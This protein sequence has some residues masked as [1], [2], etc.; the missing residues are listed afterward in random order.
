MD[1]LS[2]LQ[3]SLFS[4]CGSVLSPGGSRASLLVLMYHRVLPEPDP[5]LASEPDAR[6]FAAHLDLV[7]STF[8]V[9]ALSEAI[10]RLRTKSLPA[11]AACI[12]FD[13]GYANNFEVALPLLAARKLPATVFV[14]TLFIGGGRMWNDTVIEVV[15]RAHGELDL[16]GLGL[17]KYELGDIPARR[18]AVDIILDKLKYVEPQQRLQTV[19]AIAAHSGA[20][21]PKSLM[22]SEEMIRGLHARGVEIGAHTE[23]HPILARIS[24]DEARSEIARS[25]SVLEDVIGA[26][27][28]TF[29]YPNG[30]PRIDYDKRHVAIV[31]TCGFQG[32]VS[33]A[34][35]CARRN[36]DLFQIPRIAPWDRTAPR[37]AARLVSTYFS[38]PAETV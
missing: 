9:I 20:N 36:S 10:E 37:F 26:P 30:R 16:T 31:K 2:S 29:A 33:T 28:T 35:G 38:A 24:E 32:A 1:R 21:L 34:R 25:K 12:T 7:G 13:D 15:R 22:M 11:R 4:A 27:V 8:N 14:S 3:R 17:R 19:D 6:T 23:S 5:L 18:A